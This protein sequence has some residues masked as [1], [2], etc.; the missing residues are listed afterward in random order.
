MIKNRLF[1]NATVYMIA[2]IIN[3]AVPFLLLPIL[4]TYL[5]PS[6]FGIAATYGAF[7]GVVCVFIHLSIGSAVGVNFFKLSKMQLK[8]YIANILLIISTTTLL[9]FIIVLVFNTQLSAKLEIP[10]M[11]LLLGVIV[12][13]AQFLTILNLILWQVEQNPKAYGSYQITKMLANMS[14]VLIFVVGFEM[15]WEGQLIGQAIATIIFAL[16]SFGIVYRRGYMF[17]QIDKEY[18]ADALK[19]GIPLIPHALSGWLRTGIDRIFLTMLIS[20]SAT[21]MYAVGHQLGMV[22]GVVVMAFNQAY[23]PYLYEK[24]TDIEEKDKKKLVKFTYIYFILV[25]LF[26]GVLSLI[27]PWFI[28]YFLNEKYVDSSKFVPWI[29]FGYAFQGMY[30]MIMNYIF[31][32]KKTH[33]LAIVTFSVGLLHVLISYILIKVNGSIGAA[34][35]TSISFF[36]LFISVWILSAKIYSMPWKF[37]R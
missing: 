37:W 6:D 24:L 23:G 12:S 1:N 4:T 2:E 14:M 3:K 21:G 11:W 30:L 27:M 17:F 18:I 28:V 32:A 8:K 13:S 15:G 35:A 29:A 34:Q 7:I 22:V 36:M 19:F 25:L 26:A 9:A 10:L 31:Y 20:T 5:T 16:I 33:V